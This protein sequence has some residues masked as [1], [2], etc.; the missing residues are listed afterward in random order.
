MKRLQQLAE[1]TPQQLLTEVRGEMKHTLN[2]DFHR[3]PHPYGIT[4][5]RLEMLLV[6]RDHRGSTSRELFDH[7]KLTS[8]TRTAAER[9]IMLKLEKMIMCR[10]N[11][12]VRRWYLTDYGYEATKMIPV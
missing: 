8:A 10:V 2:R 12:G 11:D 3:K 7:L 9:L 6:L 5:D 4:N 1:R